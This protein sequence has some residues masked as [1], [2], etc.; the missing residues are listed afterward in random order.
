MKVPVTKSVVIACVC[1]LTWQG[2]Q[3]YPLYSFSFQ[4]LCKII[5]TFL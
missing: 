5:R 2:V 4:W 1:S 3:E